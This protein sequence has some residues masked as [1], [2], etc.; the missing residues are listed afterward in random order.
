MKKV[1]V[2]LIVL[3]TGSCWMTSCK[4]ESAKSA[5]DLTAAKKAIE[6]RSKIYADAVNNKDSVGVAN[7]YTKDG[8]FMPPNEKSVSGKASIQKLVGQWM[9]AGMP[10]GFSIET[11]EVWGNEEVLAAEENW[12]FK[13]KSG[14]I[15]DQ[16]KAI[17][18]YKME[19][20][21]WKLHRDCF[22]SDVVMG[23]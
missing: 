22:N 23:K 8:K 3:I 21:V 11:V 20:G 12:T 13:D 14:K 18:V 4:N 19:D 2:V 9:K 7:C 17:E 16:G 1:I 15:I 5:F 10:A 6:E